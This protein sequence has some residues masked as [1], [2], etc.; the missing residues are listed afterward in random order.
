MPATRSSSSCWAQVRLAVGESLVLAGE[1]DELSLD[2]FLL[3]DHALLDLHD[4]LASV[5]ELRVDLRPQVDGLLARLDLR[6]APDRLRLALGVLDQL[7]P[8]ALRLSDAGRA[9]RLHRKQ[10]N[11]GSCGDPDGNCDPDQHVPAPPCPQRGIPNVASVPSAGARP[12]SR[13][14]T[15]RAASVD[16]D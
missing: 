2:V 9:E 11:G 13:G 5:D 16:V 3:R 7:T 1:L 4:R 12:P 6:L 14:P 8:D 10:R 15:A